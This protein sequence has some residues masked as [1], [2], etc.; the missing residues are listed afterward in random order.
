MTSLSVAVA[1]IA[2]DK[3]SPAPVSLESAYAQLP[4]RADVLVYDS[5]YPTPVLREMRGVADRAGRELRLRPT[6][7]FANTNRV[8]NQFVGETDADVLVCLENDVAFHPGALTSLVRLLESGFCDVAVPVVHEGVRGVPHFDPVVS[9]LTDGPEGVTSELVR[10]PKNG[11]VS[12]GVLRTVDHLERHCFAMGAEAAV[13][14]GTLD[15]Q[16]YCRTD[17]DL[18]LACRSVGLSVAVT[19]NA[20]VIFRRDPELSVDRAFFDHRWN[21]DRV[22]FANARLISKWRLHGYKTTINHAH[23]IR[24]VLDAPMDTEVAAR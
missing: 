17:L 22:A 20:E 23:R 19:P 2:R 1:L 8:W 9:R 18:S 14:L 4:P 24:R 16:M 12:P 7:R 6:Q 10:R 21:L 11:L 3:F 15:E 13:R 5:G